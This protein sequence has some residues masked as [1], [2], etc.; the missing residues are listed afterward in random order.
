MNTLPPPVH[1]EQI[2]ADRKTYEATAGRRLPALVRDLQIDYTALSLAAPERNQFRVWLEGHDSG[3]QDVGTRRQAFYTDLGPGPYRFRVM[4]SNNSGVWNEAGASLDFSIAPA[5]YQTTWFRSAVVVGALALLW[6]AYQYR[7]RQVAAAFDARLQ[8]RVNERT[9]IARELHDTLL[10]SFHGLLFSLQAVSNMLPACADAKR[11]LDKAI[12]Q[13]AQAIT[14]GRDAVQNLRASTVV[15]NDLA[16]A[17]ST[18]GDDLAAAQVPNPRGSPTVVNVAVEGTSRNVHPIMRDE[19]YRIG[20]EALRN[21]FRHAGARR[22]EVAIRCEARQLQVRVRDD[23]KG[24]DQTALD[25]H[26]P[27]HFGVPGMRERAGLI[28]GHL[29]VWSKP[30]SGTEVELTIPARTA[31]A[32]PRARGRSWL[33]SR[34][35]ARNPDD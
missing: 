4:A 24:F 17:L 33:F 35:I 25:E 18:L 16:E 20:G 26:P 23:G 6:A 8:E 15:T 28:G 1:I 13:G 29:E 5:Y 19:I 12:D 27:G 34:S 2:T 7:V 3:W 22:I 31:Y 11:N 14:E 21:V 32:T 30:G 9:R 10:Q